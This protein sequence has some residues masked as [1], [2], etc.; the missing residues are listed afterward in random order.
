M[1]DQYVN[2]MVVVCIHVKWGPKD[3]PFDFHYKYKLVIKMCMVPAI[4]GSSLLYSH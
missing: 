1:D 3:N 2:E 4:I